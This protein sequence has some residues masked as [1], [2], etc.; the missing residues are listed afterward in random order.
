MDERVLRQRMERFLTGELS[1][2]DSVRSE[3]SEV[4]R[5][6]LEGSAACSKLRFR[7][8][9]RAD[10]SDRPTRPD[11]PGRNPPGGLER[12]A[13]ESW[14]SYDDVFRRVEG[15]V[16]RARSRMVSERDL[17]VPQW[18]HLSAQPQARRLVMV[19]NDKRLHTWGLFDL[20]LD[21]S[22][23]CAERTPARAVDLAQLALAIAER[24][25]AS[26]YGPSRLADFRCAALTELA[27][28]RRL[29]GN[30]TGA[31]LALTQALVHFDFGTGD[32]LDEALLALRSCELHRDLGEME[33]AG[34][35]LEHARGL[36][37]LLGDDRLR[38]IT[39]LSYPL[40]DGEMGEELAVHRVQALDGAPLPTV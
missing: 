5:C 37:R 11:R 18:T 6:L 25:D 32:L 23:R 4:V 3:S 22:R 29:A 39:L 35:E 24:L 36:F 19:H 26:L 33:R 40:R 30:L 13:S 34:R 14:S 9:Y 2:S 8:S 27:N 16:L 20:L 10:R 28:A 21:E 17:A 12:S 7:R 15:S 38:G 31:S 1:P